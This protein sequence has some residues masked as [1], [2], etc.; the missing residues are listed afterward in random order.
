M[1]IAFGC[2]DR[3]KTTSPEGVLHRFELKYADGF[4]ATFEDDHIWLDVN[5]PF[6]NAEQPFKYLLV[7]QGAPVPH[8][9]IDTQVIYI[10]IKKIVCTSTTH[11]PLLDYLNE[12]ESLVGFPTTD[13][14][15]SDKTR[16]L[17]D[18]GKVLD[19]GIDHSLNV[20]LLLSLQ[21]DLVM[22]YTIS[23]DLGHLKKIKESNIPVVINAEY[24]EK[25]PLGRVEWIKF[26]SLFY[27]K[28]QEA[29]SI[30]RILENEYLELQA[31][32]E[33]VDNKPSVMS[34]VLYGDSWFLPA[35][36]NYAAKLFNDAGMTYLWSN[37]PGTGF[38][39]LSFESVFVK[40]KEASYW[41]GASSFTS[42]KDLSS[43]DQRYEWF[44]AF[45][46]KKVYT[47]NARIGAKG[48][49]EYLELGYLRPDIILKDLVK[50]AHPE[51]L[52]THELFFFRQLD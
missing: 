5:R 8:H 27:G 4:S 3:N 2:G 52:P 50:I 11:I 21:P 15:S 20:E 39:P 51:L 24:L 10:P 22:T 46:N 38:V 13:Y 17:V 6:Q 48:G 37:E 9:D 14:I 34:G 41:I 7:K 23:G 19:L 16:K 43:A 47:Y 35:G 42:L 30:F 40:A 25:H 29:D 36:E 45:K 33:T 12:S 28:E 44:D 49:N 31:I 26:A 1:L 32:M 18:E